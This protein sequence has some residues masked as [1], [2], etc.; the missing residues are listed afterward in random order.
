MYSLEAAYA[1]NST[2]IEWTTLGD[3]IF[4]DATVVN[5]NYTVGPTDIENGITSLLMTVNGGVACE[6]ATS[7]FE[8]L[9]ATATEANAGIDAD[10]CSMLT[11]KLEDAMAANYSEILWTTTGD[12]TFD[13]ESIEHPTYFPG[14]NDKIT[15]EVTLAITA[16]N[17]TVCPTI[18]DEMLLTLYCT[19]ISNVS[20]VTDIKLYPNPNNGAFTLKLNGVVNESVGVRV[21]NA[22]GKVVYEELDI[23]ISDNYNCSID[24]NVLPGIYTIRIEG[25]STHVVQKFV[26]K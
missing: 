17:E 25:S 18:I 11:Y 10:I 20:G 9:V 26:V 19:D 3:G 15:K 6:S 14:E 7:E 21:F 23:Q 2:A 22:V 4:D 16:T 8:L 13:D 5:P 24:L 12:G 1:E